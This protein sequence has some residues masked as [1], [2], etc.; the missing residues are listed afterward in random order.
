MIKLKR[1]HSADPVGDPSALRK[2]P[3]VKS[4]ESTDAG[5]PQSV[6][7]VA[8]NAGTPPNGLA[9]PANDGSDAVASPFK[10]QRASMPGLNNGMFTSE[11]GFLPSTS[12]SAPSDAEHSKAAST[13]EVKLDA[14]KDDDNIDE[15]L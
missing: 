1:Q 6:N 12:L 7:S 8:A 9:P 10:R 11:A 5:T 4:E 15:D 3:H 13:P 14:P 2:S